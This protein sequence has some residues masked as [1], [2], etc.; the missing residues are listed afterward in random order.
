MHPG[1]T[2][3]RIEN[4]EFLF[5]WDSAPSTAADVGY[6]ETGVIAE[7]ITSHSLLIWGKMKVYGS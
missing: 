6:L 2:N 5:N 3:T 7:E 1:T 4:G